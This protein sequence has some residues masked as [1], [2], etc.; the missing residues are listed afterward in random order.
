MSTSS[1]NANISRHKLK[2]ISKI[3]TVPQNNNRRRRKKKNSSSSSQKGLAPHEKNYIFTQRSIAVSST[4]K[5]RT[6]PQVVFLIDASKSNFFSN[7]TFANFQLNSSTLTLENG[8]KMENGKIE[9]NISSTVDMRELFLDLENKEKKVDISIL[10]SVSQFE[11]WEKTQSPAYLASSSVRTKQT[12]PNTN[13]NSVLCDNI[14]AMLQFLFTKGNLID[15]NRIKYKIKK[16]SWNQYEC[17]TNPFFLEYKPEYDK[18]F[19]AKFY[20]EENARQLAKTR[21]EIATLKNKLQNKDKNNYYT[22][23]QNQLELNNK[24][25]F[26]LYLSIEIIYKEW[27]TIKRN[28]GAFDTSIQPLDDI[29]I[30]TLEDLQVSST[31]SWD[32]DP[33]QIS[34]QELDLFLT[35][36]L[37]LLQQMYSSLFYFTQMTLQTFQI[38]SEA[39]K[40]IFDKTKLKEMVRQLDK[41][42]KLV[43]VKKEGGAEQFKI[44]QLYPQ[45]NSYS[46][47]DSPT[48]HA[49]Q[50]DVE[51]EKN[52]P[53][54][55]GTFLIFDI[56]ID[57]DYFGVTNDQ[58]SARYIYV[59]PQFEAEIKNLFEFQSSKKTFVDVMQT[60]MNKYNPAFNPDRAKTQPYYDRLRNAFGI[61]SYLAYYSS[62]FP[63][64]QKDIEIMKSFDIN[65]LNNIYSTLGKQT[66]RFD[67]KI[68]ANQQNKLKD[69][70][71][72]LRANVLMLYQRNIDLSNRS[73]TMFLSAPVNLQTIVSQPNWMLQS[74]NE[75]LKGINGTNTLDNEFLFVNYSTIPNFKPSP[76][77]TIEQLKNIK[78]KTKS[79]ARTP[80]PPEKKKT[81]PTTQPPPIRMF[82][83]GP[84]HIPFRS[85]FS[86]N[87]SDSSFPGTGSANKSREPEIFFD[88]TRKI[89]GAQ[90]YEIEHHGGGSTLNTAYSTFRS[91]APSSSVPENKEINAYEA[92]FL[93]TVQPLIL[94]PLQI[95]N[96]CFNKN[97]RMTQVIKSNATIVDAF[98]YLALLENRRHPKPKAPS[99]EVSPV[100][101]ERKRSTIQQI[102]HKYFHGTQTPILY[103]VNNLTEE[104]TYRLEILSEQADEIG[105][106]KEMTKCYLILQEGSGCYIYYNVTYT[107]NPHIQD[108]D[109]LTENE[110][111]TILKPNG[112]MSALQRTNKNNNLYYVKVKLTVYYSSENRLEEFQ[113]ECKEAKANLSRDY[114]KLR[115]SFGTNGFFSQ[116]D[117]S[118]I[119]SDFMALWKGQDENKEEIDHSSIPRDGASLPTSRSDLDVAPAKDPTGKVK[120]GD[121][122]DGVKEKEEEEKVEKGEKK[123]DLRDDVEEEEGEGEGEGEGEEEGEGEGADDKEPARREGDLRADGKALEVPATETAIGGTR[124]TRRLNKYRLSQTRSRRF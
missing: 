112:E 35:G 37:K 39:K 49:I 80:L 9:F 23:I 51:R 65:L 62:V 100:L 101:E 78:M 122:K 121:L 58:N 120:D 50:N 56:L 48:V 81:E 17:N 76:G 119:R 98:L 103:L 99:S 29:P 91:S 15:I 123:G 53:V 44:T 36:I 102:Y 24:E 43:R 116:P 109:N 8:K 4:Q 69:Y 28:L 6:S 45:T 105:G 63:L 20:L 114:K 67:D 77:N 10:T 110:C 55:L 13:T 25:A 26:E 61:F 115:S 88:P 86:T 2:Q 85:D 31:H 21:E 72:Q 14:N 89:G 70:V 93:G 73:M 33:L 42:Y 111:V 82:E 59:E 75:Y 71:R 94:P 16:A 57:S 41:I 83:E 11:K 113:Q 118:G 47:R 104:E 5:T 1:R 66:Q 7:K 96:L 107:P 68:A 108:L 18:Y 19:K 52:L 54:I 22:N 40:K 3:L 106:D 30:Y 27:I 74:Q 12:T 46:S 32:K 60:L 117:F 79:V 64:F 90:A 124:R 97:I 87:R 38:F 84:T 34:S 92:P 95:D